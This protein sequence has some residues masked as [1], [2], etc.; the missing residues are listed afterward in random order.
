MRQFS[1]EDFGMAKS[2]TPLN[3]M[4]IKKATRQG[5]K[6]LIGFY[7]ESGSGKTMTA[8][9]LARGF[10]GDAGKIVL[11]DTESGRGSLYADVIPGGYDVLELREPFSPERYIEAIQ[12]AEKSGAGIVVID[13]ASHEWEGIGGVTDLAVTVSKRAAEKWNKDWD[14]NVQFGHWKE[15]KMQHSKFM[16]KMLQS[17]LPVIVCLRAKYKSR[18]LK[19][20][21][22]MVA[23]GIIKQGDIGK[24][25]VLKDEFTTPIQAEDFIFEMTAHAEILQNHTIHLT[26]CSHPSL[27]EC[28]PEGKMLEIAHGKLLA[29]WCNNASK[30][31]ASAKKPLTEVET[32]KKEL[33]NL[34]DKQHGGSKTKFRQYCVD[35]LALDPSKPV[36]DLSVAELKSLIEKAKK[37]LG[38]LV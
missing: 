18:Q 28:F 1:H 15:P 31:G 9:L 10:V 33:W 27:R 8:L 4:E 21:Q 14:G 23:D 37:K 26:K 35:E 12:T 34:T 16:L 24:S 19:G 13:S 30:P 6:P 38:Q 7:G 3:F 17:S 20:T 5:V 32:L 36:E 29:D 25:L 11:I 22:Q 2:K